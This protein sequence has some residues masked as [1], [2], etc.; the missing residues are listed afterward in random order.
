MVAGASARL[1][2]ALD[3][4]EAVTSELAGWARGAVGTRG[5]VRRLA[6][7]SMHLTLCFLGEQPLACAAELGD[8]L[9]GL[10]ELIGDVGELTVGAPVWLPPRRPHALAVEIGDPD[11]GLPRLRS[12][13]ARELTAAIG[14]RSERVR[15]RPHVTVARLRLDA[16]HGGVLPPTPP[17][18]FLAERVTMWRSHLDADGARYEALASA[19][20]GL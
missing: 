5:G 11:G 15:Y 12:E 13:L 7:E 4:P 16:L 3:V 8:L 14:W 17:L 9:D 19:P 1:F 6:P 20:A 10:V 2:I 18:R